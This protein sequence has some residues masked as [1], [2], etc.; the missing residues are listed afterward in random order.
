MIL[1]RMLQIYQG[2]VCSKGISF[3]VLI[4]KYL[5]VTGLLLNWRPLTARAPVHWS[6]GV[7]GPLTYLNHQ[8]I[9]EGWKE[10]TENM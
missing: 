7:A 2:I 3:K 6:W 10:K 5:N 1:L 8:M 9:R 4:E